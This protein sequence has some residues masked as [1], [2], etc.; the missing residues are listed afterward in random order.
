MPTF[1]RL[2]GTVTDNVGL[3]IAGANIAV[4]TQPANTSSTPGSPLATLFAD[5]AGA[6]PLANP[7]QTSGL[8]EYFFYAAAGTYTLQVYPSP[9]G[10]QFPVRLY[11]DTNVI[12][13]G[14]GTVT[15]VALTV[16]SW[17]TVSG[18]PVTST[19]TLAVSSA[20]VNANFVLAGPTTGSP[21]P[22]T[23][24]ALVAADIAGLGAGSVSSVDF[25]IT[26]PSFLAAVVSG[27]PITSSGTISVA[28]TANS[29][30]ANLVLAGPTSGGLG[31]L[32]ARS[33]VGADLPFPGASSLGGVQAFTAPSHQFF[34]QLDTSGVLHAAQPAASDLSNGVTGSGAVVLAV[35]PT[36]TGTAIVAN[37]NVGGHLD[38]GPS[39]SPSGPNTDLAGTITISSGA[40][41]QAFSFGT[42]FA[43]APVVVLT[44]TSDTTGMGTWWVTS[45]I[46]GFTAHRTN[47]SSPPA[48][49]TFNYVVVG[50]PN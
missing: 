2:N 24:R 6:T 39:G 23:P 35:S 3:P 25:A 31:A 36:L 26:V 7:V 33:L 12:A 14:A 44:P 49:V 16:P 41:T 37:L 40:T 43:S 30:A 22:L 28:V 8:G 34:T 38:A 32:T 11:P 45:T 29:V 5:P 15:N 10:V 48:A 4:L 21:G 27:T 9:A 50:N 17:L 18:S 20:N 1:Y 13:P 19:G 42:A 46:S 47:T